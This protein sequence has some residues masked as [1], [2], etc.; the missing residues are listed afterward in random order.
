MGGGTKEHL[1]GTDH[2]GRDMLVRLLYAGRVSLLVGLSAVLISGSVG[3]VTGLIAGYAGGRVDAT[4]MRLVDMQLAIPFLAL[5]I[6]VAAV[7]GPGVR[8]VIIVL[9]ISG[10]VL[11][12]RVVRASVLVARNYEY[13]MAARAIGATTFRI[14]VRTI[15]PN[16]FA[17][18]L[19]IGTFSVS[20]MIITES[21]L[22]FLGLGVPPATAT[23]GAML[24]DARDYLEVAWWIPTFPGLA[25]TLVVLN[26][27]LI[28]D[29]LRDRLDPR[30]RV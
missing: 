25:I 26:V 10:W 19:V 18:A 14:L 29:W 16:V 8:N 22:S 20:Q 21:S 3:V 12:A 2:L 17:P 30:L 5:A 23:W 7:V 4:I 27:N 11:Y 15:L 28:G 24:S 1:L 13:V 6:L 9:G